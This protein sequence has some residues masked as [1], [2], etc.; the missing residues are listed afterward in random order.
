MEGKGCDNCNNTGYKG[1]IA[2]YEVMVINEDLQEL[3][4]NGATTLELKKFAIKSGMLTMRQSGVLRI[5]E[6]ITTIGEVINTTI[7]D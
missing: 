6:G 4:L 5:K 3:I 7:A 1:R 2:L